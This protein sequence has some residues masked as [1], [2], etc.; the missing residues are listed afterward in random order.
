MGLLATN[1]WQ[2]QWI[3]RTTNTDE[4]PAP[5]F[6]RKLV[7]DGKV[8]KARVY[9]C[10][11][12][13]YELHINGRKV[14]DHLRD[15]GYTRYDKRD[16]YVTYDV[17]PFLK[18]GANAVGVILGNG[19]FNVQIAKAVLEFLHEA[20]WREAPRLLLSLVIE[21]ADGRTVPPS[22]AMEPGKLPLGRSCSTVFTAARTTMRD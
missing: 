22:A 7:L 9:I 15:P 1:D 14:G 6:R 3:A 10:G 8:K 18:S 19:W 5:F 13:Y 17:T 12:G 20:P 21:Y 2:A 4:L 16:L 11:L